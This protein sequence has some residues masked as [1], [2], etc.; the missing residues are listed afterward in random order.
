MY[1]HAKY[2][3]TWFIYFDA[4]PRKDMELEM[5]LFSTYGDT[6]KLG[7][8][9]VKLSITVTECGFKK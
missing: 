3:P 8:S 7:V 4:L 9:S 5:K 6:D 2:H 1:A